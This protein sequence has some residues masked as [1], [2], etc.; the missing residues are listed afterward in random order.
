ME[1][2][3]GS[4]KHRTVEL[5]G[6]TVGVEPDAGGSFWISIDRV[7]AT[8]RFRLRATP[9][10]VIESLTLE[11]PRLLVPVGRGGPRA[12][13]IQHLVVEGADVQLLPV[14]RPII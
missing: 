3:R 7:S 5:H 12:L 1:R 2:W 14:K 6:V 11:R 13:A 10:L 4:L 8:L 9:R